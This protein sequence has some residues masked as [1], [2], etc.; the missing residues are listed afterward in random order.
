M[1][2]TSRLIA[3]SVDHARVAASG[4]PRLAPIAVPRPRIEEW[5]ER[6]EDSQALLVVAPVGFGKTTAVIRELVRRG[7]QAAYVRLSST[8]VPDR[9]RLRMAKMLGFPEPSRSYD[10]LLEQL[11]SAAPLTLCVDEIDRAPDATRH[12]LANLLV[13]APPGVLLIYVGRSRTAIALERAV[14]KG[15]ADVCDPS[16]LPFDED[17]IT[18]LARAYNVSHAAKEIRALHAATEG[19][20]V[21]I[22]AALRE[23]AE[24]GTGAGGAY[25]AWRNGP[26]RHFPR[27]VSEELS[28]ASDLDRSVLQIALRGS[29]IS[30]SDALRL[31]DL[32]ARGL[33]V[34]RNG[35][36]YAPFRVLQDFSA[37]LVSFIA[38]AVVAPVP[39]LTVKMLGRFEASIGDRPI[40]WVRRRDQQLFKYLL[41]QS[42]GAATRGELLE[43]FWSGTDAQLATQSLRTACSNIR[44]AIAGIVGQENVARYFSS[45]GDVGINF[46]NAA[47]DLHRFTA[48]LRDGDAELERGKTA[49]ALAFYRTAE[50]LYSGGLFAGEAPEPWYEA[51]AQAYEALYV[52]L[53]ERLGTLSNTQKKREPDP[54][55]ITTGTLQ[56][57]TDTNDAELPPT[58]YRPSRPLLTELKT[59]TRRL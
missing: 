49:E 21:V 48:L 7:R 40:E 45:R 41:L 12:D 29:E 47:T 3:L 44:K 39:S 54:G 37:P 10:E 34:R 26:G 27:Y 58:V 24:R 28:R 2:N 57:A 9:L 5:F 42:S 43:T 53:L 18:S 55:A 46:A 20:P 36:T 6:H 15:V 1:S 16:L 32:E 19:W 50:A 8:D 14:A 56:T 30:E 13:D 52:G 35:D 38:D 51:K 4:V 25:A 17:E 33:L 11:A 59:R 23:A 22:A 31:A